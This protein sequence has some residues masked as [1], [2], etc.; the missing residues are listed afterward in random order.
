MHAKTPIP[1]T[2]L[3]ALLALGAAARDQ[4]PGPTPAPL[5]GPSAQDSAQDELR[6][7]F[8][9]VERRLRE[10]DRLLGDAG[11]GD[12]SKLEGVGSSGID[13][14]LRTARE[15]QG[16]V[17]EDIDRMLEIAKQFGSTSESGGGGPAQPQGQAQG[18]SPLDR[19]GEQTTQREGTPSQPQGEKPEPQPKPGQGQPGEQRPDDSQGEPK[20][21]RASRDTDPKNTPGGPQGAQPTDAPQHPADEVDRWGDL[22]VHARDVF[23][24]E[25]GGD[26]PV[27][28]RDWIDAYYR[29]LNRKK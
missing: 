18:Q 3:L 26:M 15:R 14:L 29:R 22:P 20:D 9:K 2:A 17:I 5:E 27:Q 19:S 8:Q 10:I 11:A 4:D 25:G 1:T 23:R 28:Y 13:Q 24:A 21:P 12:V 16:Q 7:L 6:E